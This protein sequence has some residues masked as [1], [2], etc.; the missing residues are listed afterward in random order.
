MTPVPSDEVR[1]YVPLL[2]GDDDGRA[3][4]RIMRGFG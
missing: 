1:A 2:K 4:L 3:F